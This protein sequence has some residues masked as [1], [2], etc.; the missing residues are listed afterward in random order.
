MGRQGFERE[1]GDAEEVVSQLCPSH[2]G[3]CS[4][5]HQELSLGPAVKD[6]ALSL[7]WH[8]PISGPGNFHMTW[9]WPKNKIS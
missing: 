4:K 3:L 8:G 7:L 5:P 1:E 6:L 2:P 9:V